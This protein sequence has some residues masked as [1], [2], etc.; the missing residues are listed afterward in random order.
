M[1]NGWQALM[2]DNSKVL[3]MAEKISSEKNVVLF[4]ILLHLTK[5]NSTSH[6]YRYVFEM[7]TNLGTPRPLS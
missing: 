1:V 3:G 4:E 7:M 6:G 5:M 2:R